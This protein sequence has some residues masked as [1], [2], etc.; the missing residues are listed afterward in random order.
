MYTPMASRR[1]PIAE[2]T[3]T[4]A[5]IDSEQKLNAECGMLNLQ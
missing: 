1:T 2:V 3:F 4:E 5:E